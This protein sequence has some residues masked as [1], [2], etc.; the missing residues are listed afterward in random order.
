MKSLNELKVEVNKCLHKNLLQIIV[1]YVVTSIL[2]FLSMF[3]MFLS[4]S[5][6]SLTMLV[7]TFVVFFVACLLIYGLIIVYYSL[8]IHKRT[9]LGHLFIGFYDI[10]RQFVLVLGLFII[11]QLLSF[12]LLIPYQHF[13][14]DLSEMIKMS[15]AISAIDPEDTEALQAVISSTAQPIQIDPNI[16]IFLGVYFVLLLIIIFNFIF[17][18]QILYTNSKMKILQVIK[19]N[20]E[21]L[22]GN[23]IKLLLLILKCTGVYLVCLCI[24]LALSIFSLYR[25]IPSFLINIASILYTVG[26]I[27]TFIKTILAINVYYS[28]LTVIDIDPSTLIED[29]PKTDT[30]QITE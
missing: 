13:V 19:T 25:T 2:L 5:A 10:K 23:F 4:Y 17:I 1:T 8:S 26:G 21:L 20:F 15:P 27:C 18:P 9:V 24:G 22:K 3:I 6:S 29:E 30:L 28:S 11:I 7:I 12:I 14:G 16:F